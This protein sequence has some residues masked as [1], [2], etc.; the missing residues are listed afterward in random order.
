MYD[1]H[2]VYKHQEVEHIC[3]RGASPIF[4]VTVSQGDLNYTK[5]A[6]K[7]EDDVHDDVRQMDRA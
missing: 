2:I 4:C 3:V 7:A 1:E 6:R 5:V